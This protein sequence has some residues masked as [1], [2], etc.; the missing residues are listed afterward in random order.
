MQPY[1][2]SSNARQ[3]NGEVQGWLTKPGPTESFLR[4]APKHLVQDHWESTPAIPIDPDCFTT[5][6]PTRSF[7]QSR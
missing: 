6:G 2:T 7:A 4:S 5:V 3:Q 1:E